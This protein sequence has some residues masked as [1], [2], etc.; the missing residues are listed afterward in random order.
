MNIKI[1][2]DSKGGAQMFFRVISGVTAII[3]LG[4]LYNYIVMEH[5]TLIF[6]K[7]YYGPILLPACLYIAFLFV[8]YAIGGKPLLGKI[9]PNLVGKQKEVNE[10]V[11][12]QNHKNDET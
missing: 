6:S 1:T 4:S 12:N 11:I 9:I 10:Q 5:K 8:I 7:G 3:I 2:K